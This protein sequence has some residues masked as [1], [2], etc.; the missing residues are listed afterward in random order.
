MDWVI[1]NALA[2]AFLP[3]GFLLLVALWGLALVRRH[4]LLGRSLIT[5]ALLAL[6]ALSTQYVADTLLQA[7]EAPPG[8]PLTNG[9]GQAIVVLG[10][11]TYFNAPEYSA[12]TVSAGGL[13]RLRYA[14]HLHRLT[15]KPILASG[16]SPEGAPAAEAAHMRAALQRDFQVPVEWIEDRSRTTV[17]NARLSHQILSTAGIRTIYL[18][19]HAWHMP[20]ARLAFEDAGFA[21]IPA[22]TGYATRFRLTLLDFLP[23]ARALRDSS[24]F[25]HE[26]IGIAWYRLQFAVARWK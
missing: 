21:V 4:P 7:L 11:G 2:A 17:E 14:A 23:D 12:T 9:R 22:A 18:V 1:R 15:R 3:P 24:R 13:V 10:A 20:R 25:F 6:Y 5:L 8:D 26:V 19:T 16:G